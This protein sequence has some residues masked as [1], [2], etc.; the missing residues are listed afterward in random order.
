MIVS[1]F[2]DGYAIPVARFKGNPGMVCADNLLTGCQF[3]NMPTARAS[4]MG[5]Y[6]Q[7][8]AV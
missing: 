7:G 2:A 3:K 4:E 5:F 6:Q 8:P 1:P